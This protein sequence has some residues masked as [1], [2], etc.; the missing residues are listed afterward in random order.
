MNHHFGLVTYAPVGKYAMLFKTEKEFDIYD[1][2][3]N[4]CYEG[5]DSWNFNSSTGLVTMKKKD[6]PDIQYKIE[7]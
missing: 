2:N 6:N 3:G 1:Y 7:W 5:Y 4:L